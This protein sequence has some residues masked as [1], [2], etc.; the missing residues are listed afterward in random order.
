MFVILSF[1]LVMFLVLL[2]CSRYSHVA[3][4]K[5]RAK[6]YK[7]LQESKREREE[8]ADIPWITRR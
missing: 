6:R 5:N 1:M 2:A 3:P 7:A 4:T 8:L